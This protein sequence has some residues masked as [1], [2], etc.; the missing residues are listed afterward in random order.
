MRLF[1]RKKSAVK[2]DWENSQEVHSHGHAPVV[3]SYD[4]DEGI[5]EASNPE[6]TAKAEEET[7]RRQACLD[8]YKKELSEADLCKGCSAGDVMMDTFDVGN[9]PTCGGDEEKPP[10]LLADHRRSLSRSNSMNSAVSIHDARGMSS[11]RD[12]KEG[13]ADAMEGEEWPVEKD[14]SQRSRLKLALIACSCVLLVALI[15]MV[16]VIV[17]NKK[18]G[19]YDELNL[20]YS[21]DAEGGDSNEN[22]FEEGLKE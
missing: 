17:K 5:A 3:I 2:V 6:S 22:I 10:E 12:G 14:T 19:S 4:Q 11:I 20:G 7:R 13:Y 16:A 9:K 1:G 21:T 15:T 8:A 18:N